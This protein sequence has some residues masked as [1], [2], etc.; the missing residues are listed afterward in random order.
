MDRFH[1]GQSQNEVA[2][3]LNVNQ[4]TISRLLTR[5]QQTG[6]SNDNTRSGRPCITTPGQDRYIRIFHLRTRTVSASTTAVWIPGLRRIS[7]QA[8]RNRFRQ[9]GIRHRRPY[10]GAHRRT[11]YDTTSIV[12]IHFMNT[13]GR[14]T[15]IPAPVC[16]YSAIRF[17]RRKWD[18]SLNQILRPFRNVQPLNLLIQWT[19]SRL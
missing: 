13:G 1:A 15:F 2:Q 8:V 4:S 7:S 3:T 17:C 6:S 5:C 12:A 16:P 14:E 10:L 19:L 9:H 11:H 18:S